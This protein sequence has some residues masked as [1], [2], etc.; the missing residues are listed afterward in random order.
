MVRKKRE[1]KEEVDLETTQ[2]KE[3]SLAAKVSNGKPGKVK[4]STPVG[5]RPKKKNGSSSVKVDSDAETEDDDHT[6][7]W[8]EEPTIENPLDILQNPT[9]ALEMSEDPV[10]LY[11]KEIGQINL[12]DADSEFRLA[13][14]IEAD[15]IV[16]TLYN[17]VEATGEENKCQTIF[18][19]VIQEVV[20]SWVALRSDFL[21][22]GEKGSTG[23]SSDPVGSTIVTPTMA[24]R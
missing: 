21:R 11:L 15:R 7:E 3:A 16:E 24:F 14:R 9:I 20:S 10:R 17:Q 12:L 4:S 5:T 23:Y 13:A 18:L 22:P 19:A 6:E 2:L 8:S 1:E